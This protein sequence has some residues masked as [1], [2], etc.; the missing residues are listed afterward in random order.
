M[1][2]EKLEA[3]T[4]LASY[5]NDAKFLLFS[6]VAFYTE[7]TRSDTTDDCVPEEQSAATRLASSWEVST[8]VSCDALTAIVGVSRPTLEGGFNARAD[9]LD[10]IDEES[11][12]ICVPEK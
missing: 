11:K 4:E 2:F 10:R 3:E 9:V 6:W 7:F 1:P 8:K 12:A 5:M